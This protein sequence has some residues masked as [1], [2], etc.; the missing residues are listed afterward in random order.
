MQILRKEKFKA[1]QGC[2]RGHIF[3]DNA[4]LINVNIVSR[5]RLVEYSMFPLA[6]RLV[7]A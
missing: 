2:I 6:E 7:P 5:G 1:F 3:S 4:P